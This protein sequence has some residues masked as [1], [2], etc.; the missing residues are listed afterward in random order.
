VFGRG[1]RVTTSIDLRLQRLARKAIA[2]SLTDPDGPTA[3][4][5]AIDPRDG[6]VLAMVGGQ[7]FRESEFNL[8]V[9]SQ[10]QPGSVFKPFVLAAALETGIAPGSTFVSKPYL[11][12]LGD[13]LWSVRN[14][15][16]AYLGSTTLDN[17]TVHSD[18]TVYAQLTEIVGPKAV[19]RTAQRL[20]IRSPLESY[21]A[22]GLG[23]EAVNPLELARA[24]AAFPTNGLRL[25]GSIFGNVPRAV[26]SVHDPARTKPRENMV[27]PRRVL[28]DSTAKTV[29][30]ILQRVVSQGTG[31][32]AWLPDRPVAGK[33]GT[34][35]NYGDAWFVGYTPQ[36][37][38]AVWVG[39][40]NTLKPMETE[41]HGD[42][43]A[44]GTF[45]AEIWK[46][47]AAS[48]LRL[49]RE[50]PASFE[51][52]PFLAG[53]TKRVVRRDGRLLL[54]NGICR[55]A[56]TVVYFHGGPTKTA[57]CKPNEVD[58]PRV[59]GQKLEVAQARLAAQ[60]LQW[61]IAYVPAKP[62]QRTDR[63]VRQVPARGRLSSHDTVTLFLPR[64]LHGVVPKLRGLTV[65]QARA[66][67]AK[68]GLKPDVAGF[69]DGREGTVVAQAPAP[70]LAARKGMV[71]SLIVGRGQP[72]TAG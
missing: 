8:A 46:S 47:F 21:F 18:N 26:L 72:K 48:A 30:S 66:K 3:S 50:E 52:P 7:N 60:P 17:A 25:D 24:Y 39:Y 23:A 1:Y 33:T 57:R 14:Y 64:P 71:V 70:G 59:V 38:V 5:V 4:L 2:E 43:V 6:S 63:V 35:E 69:T 31:K 19:A 9:Q 11:I 15:E 42:P 27:V 37:V 36:L 20:G 34:T 10:R 44:G 49:R 61:Q 40:P 56:L 55:R 68:A 41:F 54:D 62:L 65:A 28:K 32:R 29:N 16:N 45:P 51:P 13:R 53:T 22:I 58:V 12:S 67:L